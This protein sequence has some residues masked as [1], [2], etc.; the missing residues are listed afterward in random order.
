VRRARLFASLGVALFAW[1]VTVSGSSS[2]WRGGRHHG[3]SGVP[4]PGPGR[5]QGQRTAGIA[6]TARSLPSAILRGQVIDFPTGK[7]VSGVKVSASGGIDVAGLARE[8]SAVSGDRGAFIL[9]GLG[10]GTIRLTGRRFDRATRVP[11]I[12]PLTLGD[13]VASVEVWVDVA[14]AIRGSV[15]S[16]TDPSRPV[17]GIWVRARD[18]STGDSVSSRRAS[19]ADG[20]FEIDGLRPAP[21]VLEVR[22]DDGPFQPSGAGVVVRE[23]D[24]LDE[25]ITVD[26]VPAPLRNVEPAGGGRVV[27]TC[28]GVVSGTV[29]DVRGRPARSVWVDARPEDSEGPR[30]EALDPF[31]SPPAE[32]PR[33]WSVLTGGDGRFALHGLCGSRSVWLS[34]HALS[35]T[36]RATQ[37]AVRAGDDVSL[38]LG[39]PATLLGN[40]RRSGKA[41]ASF[42]CILRGPMT[43]RERVEDGDGNF[44]LPWLDPGHYELVVEADEG[45][46]VTSV[47]L[48]PN[49]VRTLSI[50]LS[51]GF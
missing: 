16:R 24:V 4:R 18:R 2:A 26:E 13:E 51:S 40:V 7:G 30:P 3:C 14:F 29:T 36:G 48:L 34:A 9:R 42:V 27:E 22:S 37:Q 33:E 15:T 49:D 5:G 25:K 38:I 11:T 17:A 45:R 23:T 19:G 6:G 35:S 31:A 46:S 47:D 10:P 20:L 44:R 39:R 43:R 32:M 28:G 41:V 21:Y 8:V 1:A 12:V 50:V